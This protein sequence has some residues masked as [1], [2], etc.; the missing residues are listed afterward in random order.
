MSE[1]GGLRR[2][3]WLE[4]D[5]D[6]LQHNV[7]VIRELVGPAVA[8][9]PVVKADAYGHG[10]DVVGP[11]LAAASDALCV[12]TLDEALALRAGGVEGRLI[13]LYPVPRAAVAAAVAADIELT[14]MSE[15]D[16]AAV[17]AH[18]AASSPRRA[19]VHLDVDTGM[20]RGG[21]S[22]ESAAALARAI[23]RAGSIELVGLWTHL[24]SAAEREV[25][26]MQVA[27]LEVAGE[28]IRRSGMDVP[29]RH[30]A[31]SEG[32]FAG[33]APA[34]E[35]VRPGLAVY[36]VLEE[37]LGIAAHARS[38]AR[39]LRPAMTLKARAVAFS[40]V[41]TGAGVGYG[42]LWRAPC[43]SRV[44]VLPIGYADGYL[45]ATQPVA[46]VLLRGRRFPVVGAISMDAITV[47]VTELPDIDD[48]DEFVLMGA[49]GGA[50]IPA[51]ELARWRN[52]IAREVL[53]GMDA[54]LDRVYNRPA[55]SAKENAVGTGQ[56]HDS[57]DQPRR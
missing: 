57:S 38:A 49:Q 34:F 46:S 35:L 10:L 54:R 17:L 24:A 55:G 25:S 47:D 7:G 3:A 19:R 6:A 23:V 50:S 53:S 43:P 21:L 27:R 4:I 5:L 52:T 8:V 28:A 13:L 30:V 36:G 44:A 29:A 51:T 48:H 37:S 40:D 14:L 9:A 18:A 33:T 41:P 11:V 45:R 22:A 20:A 15:T 56:T 1:E 42:S 31:A 32:L 16:A 26:A 12:A 39:A 2:S